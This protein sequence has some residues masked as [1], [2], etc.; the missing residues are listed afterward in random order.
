MKKRVLYAGVDVDD[1]AFHVSIYD[2]TSESSKEFS[3]KPVAGNLVKKLKQQT[4]PYTSIKVCY[5][6]SHIG[7][8][9]VRY[10]RTNEIEC[11]VIAPGQTPVI[12]GEKRKTD[13]LD[14]MKLAR[15]F[16]YGLLTS[17]R[18]P[19]EDNEAVRGIVRSR[20]FLLSQMSAMKKKIVMLSRIYG[21]DYRRETNKSSM[22]TKNHR[23]WLASKIKSCS[24]EAQT[25]AIKILVSQ[26]HQFETNLAAYD[27]EI[28]KISQTPFYKEK[29]QALRCFRG[30]DTLSS[31]ILI[32]EIFDIKR[33][34]HPRSLMS[35]AGYDIREYSSGGKEKKYGITRAGNRHIRWILTEVCQF[36]LMKPGVSKHLQKRRIGANPEYCEIADRCMMRLYKKGS[37]LL[38]SGKHRNKVIVACS[39]EMLGFIWEALNAAEKQQTSQK[40][41]IA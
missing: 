13:R 1:K 16:S 23:L 30:L 24:N 36:A 7:F 29:V 35:Y 39:R 28:E 26:L 20:Y 10:L 38:H 15:F 9:L 31:M 2:L 33:F 32:T 6:A 4:P 34:S 18:V 37:K 19:N 40:K 22:W 3:C 21:W 12:P 14:C 8:N 25:I 11:E 5:E 27:L 17:V 41:K